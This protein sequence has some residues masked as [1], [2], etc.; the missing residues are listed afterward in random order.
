MRRFAGSEKPK[1]GRYYSR[2]APTSA[3][4]IIT[5]RTVPHRGL[6]SSA[7]VT[8]VLLLFLCLTAVCF[9][10]RHLC[11]TSISI[12]V[13]LGGLFSSASVTCVILLFLD[14]SSFGVCCYYYYYYY[15]YYEHFGRLIE[16]SPRRLQKNTLQAK[17]ILKYNTSVV[18]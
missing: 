1:R 17:L 2:Q 12:S 6:F 18:E 7:S 13:P 11:S 9:H 14:M 15:Y 5:L 4:K 8:C 16:Q 3:L 10:R